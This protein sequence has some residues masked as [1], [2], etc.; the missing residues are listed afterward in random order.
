MQFAPENYGIKAEEGLSI[1]MKPQANGGDGATAF[2][3][4]IFNVTVTLQPRN[5]GGFDLSVR[6]SQQQEKLTKLVEKL[7][8]RLG[9][10]WNAR[11]FIE[12]IALHI[13][14]CHLR[15]SL[16]FSQHQL[17]TGLFQVL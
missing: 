13:K 3:G 6:P 4:S 9:S 17:L 15:C 2:F 5:G 16:H 8:T 12:V 14:Y 10:V 1:R 7:E 11:R